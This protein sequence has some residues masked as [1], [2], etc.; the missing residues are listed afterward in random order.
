MDTSPSTG[1]MLVNLGTPAA[2]ETAPVRRYL[3]QFLSDFRVLT[4]PAPLRWSLLNLVIL[5]TRSARS[6]AAYK[7]IWGPAGSPLLVHSRALAR[8]VA[9]ELG[10]AYHVE[11][12]MRYGEPSIQQGL[13][14]LAAAGVGRLLVLPL[15]PQYAAAVTASISAEV[16]TQLNRS[17]DIPPLEILGAFFDEPDFLESWREISGPSLD[18]FR[19]DHVLF[20]FHGLPEDQIRASDP[21]KRHCLGSETCCEAPGQSLRRCYRAQCYA[22][23]RGL[24][25]A[26]GLDGSHT[27]VSFQSR[28]GRQPWIQP[29][30]DGVLPELATRGVKRLAVFCPS[31][32]A[33][34]LETLEEIGIQLRQRWAEIGGEALWV[35]PCPNGDPRFAKAVAGWIQRRA[36]TDA[37]GRAGLRS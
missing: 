34:C 37:E 25:E 35:A 1:V 36:H 27:S 18:A 29:Y 20:S 6:A 10:D 8:A 19:A 2:P 9:E 14:A 15:F 13:D 26:L 3:R 30:T 5:P 17:G 32:V 7:K 11:L 21:T 23:A 28:L 16:F 31:F 33:D 22:T 24:G 4:L 12:A